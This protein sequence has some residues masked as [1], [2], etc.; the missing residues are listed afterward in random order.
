MRI[1]VGNRRVS[2]GHGVEPRDRIQ[3]G[4][5]CAGGG[6]GRDIRMFRLPNGLGERAGLTAP[7]HIDDESVVGAGGDAGRNTGDTKIGT[8]VGVFR[9]TGRGP[10]HDNGADVE[11]VDG[12]GGVDGDGRTRRQIRCHDSADEHHWRQRAFA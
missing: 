4:A 8:G 5:H 6:Q 10:G 3:F 12:A 7:D 9:K 1:P 2:L 11:L